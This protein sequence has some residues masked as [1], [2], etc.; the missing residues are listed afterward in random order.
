MKK[1]SKK[2]NK[3]DKCICV[4]IKCVYLFGWGGFWMCENKDEN[5]M[6]SVYTSKRAKMSWEIEVNCNKQVVQNV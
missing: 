6:V 5:K 4:L 2:A 3:K 1:K